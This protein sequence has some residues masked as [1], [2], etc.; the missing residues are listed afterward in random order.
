N[1]SSTSFFPGDKSSSYF[2]NDVDVSITARFQT[3]TIAGNGEFSQVYKVE[4]PLAGTL[5]GSQAACSPSAKAWAVKKSRK[6]YTGQKDRQRKMREVRVLKALRGSENIVEFVDHWE[7]K[8]HL[9]I[10]T[11]FCE[12]GN[13][14]D[15]LLRTGF[16]GRLDDFR[17]WKILLELSQG[18][19]SIHDANFIH[20]DLKPANV[21]LDWEGVL[22]L[23][24]FGMASEWPAPAHLD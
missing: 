21:L 11:E 20:L 3:A 6:P 2:S 12:N 13:L 4:K 9:Y 14:K 19:K 10:Q 1:N 17:V 24:D 18:L 8:N 23:A 15:F 22:K 7:A 5:Q 16:K